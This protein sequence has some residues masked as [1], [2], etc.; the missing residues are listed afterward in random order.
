MKIVFIAEEYFRLNGVR[1]TS[2]VQYNTA[3]GK[4]FGNDYYGVVLQRLAKERQIHVNTFQELVE[5]RP[6]D[7]VAIFKDNT[8]TGGGALKS[9]NY[10]LLHVSP[11]HTA[12]P[13][14]RE[15]GI[16]DA[17]GFVDV[18]QETLRH[19][20][21][22]N[23]YS[24]GDCSSV[25]TSKTAVAITAE[26]RVLKH[27][28]LAAINGQQVEDEKYDGYTCCPLI[29][30]QNTLIL[31]EFSGFTAQ[32]MET[33]PVDQ[34]VERSSAQFL[35]KEVR[36][37]GGFYTIINHRRSETVDIRRIWCLTQFMTF[38]RSSL[39]STGLA[40]CVGNGRALW[41]SVICLL[42]SA[43]RLISDI[44]TRW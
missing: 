23:I 40:S 1:D 42:L 37:W 3:A 5:V 2:N 25:P 13:F 19:K 17:A 18:S 33:F 20:K 4:I 15:S 12:P 27:N 29:T 28:L 34:R 43:L 41:N 21:Y 36:V 10:D 7:R 30:G 38:S 8:P 26:S 16:G 32:P 14:I 9:V 35:N 24:L 31:A 22:P 39:R 44:M 6:A 11:T